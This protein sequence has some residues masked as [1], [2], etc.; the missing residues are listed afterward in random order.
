VLGS[1]GGGV[2]IAGWGVM[3]EE[4]HGGVRQPGSEVLLCRCGKDDNFCKC[5][6]CLTL[7]VFGGPG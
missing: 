3:V 6:R 4:I 2:G 5:V 7:E 1:G